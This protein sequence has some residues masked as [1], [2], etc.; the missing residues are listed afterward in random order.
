MM[1]YGLGFDGGFGGGIAGALWGIGMFAVM[2]G[3]VVLIVWAIAKVVQPASSAP[4][5]PAQP[6]PLDLLRARF[7]RGEITE[8]EFAQAKHI[9]G[10]DR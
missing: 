4:G 6:E 3:I 5:A 7:A 1:G 2:V 9:L 8:A 10:Y